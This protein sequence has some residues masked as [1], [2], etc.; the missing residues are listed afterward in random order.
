MESLKCFITV[1]LSALF[2]Y[3]EPVQHLLIAVLMLFAVNFIVGFLAD[4]I[5]NNSHFCFKKAFSFIRE[6]TVC[7]LLLAIVYFIGDHLNAKKE[8]VHTISTIAYALVY[9]YS[10]NISR[11]LHQLLPDSKAI[12]I[13]YELLSIEI[14]SK[15]PFNHIFKNKQN[16]NT[17]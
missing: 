3:F 9:F 8:A 5:H 7:L 2:A 11:N 10:V 12:K 1:S 6:A 13:L 17:D 4:L 15:M 14:V 16:A